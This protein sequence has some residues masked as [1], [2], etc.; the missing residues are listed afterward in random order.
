MKAS[1]LAEYLLEL[2]K[3]YN[4]P[5]VDILTETT[6]SGQIEQ[7]AADIAYSPRENRIKILPEDF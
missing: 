3:K 2:A 6:K 5:E 7:P 1:K 4:D